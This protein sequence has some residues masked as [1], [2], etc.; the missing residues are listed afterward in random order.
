[1]ADASPAQ[2]AARIDC[3]D[4]SDRRR[5]RELR[6]G[7]SLA[8]LIQSELSRKGDGPVEA[9]AEDLRV[10]A[11]E[12]ARSN[13][14]RPT[15]QTDCERDRMGDERAAHVPILCVACQAKDFTFSCPNVNSKETAGVLGPTG[16]DLHIESRNESGGGD[17]E[18]DDFIHDNVVV[19]YKT[20]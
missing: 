16:N 11:L 6:V 17:G 13:S 14:A 20:R 15:P 1:V 10:T 2:A 9:R 3:C 4:I 5:A 18:I 8:N 19:M 12:Q 7:F